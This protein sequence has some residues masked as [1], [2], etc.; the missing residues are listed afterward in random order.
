[1]I[2]ALVVILNVTASY[3]HIILTADTVARYLGYE[4]SLFVVPPIFGALVGVAGAGLI[5]GSL[6]QN[7][8]KYWWLPTLGIA[9]TMAPICLVIWAMSQAH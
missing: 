6:K 1:M 8:I 2:G 7:V 4:I 9:M 5:Q 3:M